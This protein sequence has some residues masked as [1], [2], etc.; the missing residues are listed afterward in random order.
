MVPLST[1]A[2]SPP[3]ADLFAIAGPTI[4]PPLPGHSVPVFSGCEIIVAS[5]AFDVC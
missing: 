3:S 1:V 2:I 5:E 4:L